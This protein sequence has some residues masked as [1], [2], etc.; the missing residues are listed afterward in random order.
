[1]LKII[2]NYSEL[3]ERQVMDIYSESNLDNTSY[4][5]P[6]ECD[7]KKALQLVE[8]DFLKYIRDE[9]LSKEGNSYCVYD[10]DGR[11]VSA[12]RLY[13]LGEAFC[14][15]EALE[16]RPDCRRKGYGAALLKETAD[17]FARQGNVRI[18]D[19]VSKKNIASLRTHEKCGFQIVS[20]QGYDYL[21]GEANDGDYG[22]EYSSGETK[23]AFMR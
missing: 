15:I 6:D 8:R 20:E 19:C 21:Q 7:K 9:F 17:Y 18:C 1:M 3:D 14:Y 4:F 13:R 23:V 16:T 10:Q 2:T 22:M 5:Y 11:W 12:L